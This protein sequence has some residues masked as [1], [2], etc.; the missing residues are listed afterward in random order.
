MA[1]YK[2]TYTGYEGALTPEWSRFLIL[3][4]AAYGRLGQMKLLTILRMV[5]LF[6]PLG[7]IV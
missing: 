1:V 3:P 5:S 2:R 4:R 6:Y 7:C